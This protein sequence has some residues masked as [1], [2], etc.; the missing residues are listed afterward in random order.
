MQ[1]SNESQY[2]YT[3]KGQKENISHLR[4]DKSIIRLLLIDNRTIN[5]LATL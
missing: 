1:M 3:F 4:N 2:N 5:I